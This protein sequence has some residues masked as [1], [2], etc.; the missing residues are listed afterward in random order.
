MIRLHHVLAISVLF[1]VFHL[2]PASG[3]DD[4][5]APKVIFDPS[6]PDSVKLITPFSGSDSDVTFA[7]TGTGLDVNVIAGGKAK[8]PGITITPAA[9]LDA[10]GYGHLEF[11]CTNNGTKKIRIT[12]KVDNA[13]PW[14]ENRNSVD[15]TGL[16]PGETKTVTAIFG[17]QFGKPGYALDPKDIS[18][19]S[20]FSVPSDLAESYHIEAI[21]AAGPTGEK[22][23]V[24]PNR[25]AVIPAGGVLLGGDATTEGKLLAPRGGAKSAF[26]ADG[27]SLQVDFAG[28]KE[29]LVMFKP[30]AGMWN[31]NE[32][33]EVKVHVKNTGSSPVTP[34][35]QLQSKAGDSDPVFAAAPIAPGAEADI[36]I[37]FA[38]ATPWKCIVDPDQEKLE[39][40]KDWIGENQ[41]GTGTKYASNSTV[42]V[43][44][45][46]D[47]S[48][49]AKSFQVTSIVGDMP[50]AD[51]LPDWLGQKPPVDGDWTKTFEDNFDGNTID[52]K[53]WN[54]YF[55]QNYYLGVR[56]HYSKDNVI[57]KDGTVTLRIEKKDG[58]QN[59]DPA[60]VANSYAM[61][62]LD[63]YGKWTQRY[64]YFE[65]RMKLTKS[66]EVTPCFW[67]MPDRGLT[68]GDYNKRASTK[69]GGMELDIMETL[70]IWGLCRHDFGF[71]WDSYQK[72]HKSTGAVTLYN[73]PDKDGFITVGLL[74]TPGSLVEYDNGKETGRWES[75]RI[76][77]VESDF[78]LYNIIGGWETEAFDDKA[79]PSDFVIDYVRAWQRKDLASPDDGPKPNDGAPYPP[80][81]TATA[82]TTPT[83]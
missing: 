34:G 32:D 19:I 57:V 24:D 14:Q 67:L 69:D 3:T 23:F 4:P 5:A 77:N 61:G 74:W 30:A 81:T 45:V 31:L 56:G 15:I 46:S 12:F 58:H 8:Y 80:G 50:T 82:A 1:S 40:K 18:S 44:F 10:S 37:P 2:M 39:V 21:Q 20:I 76:S 79:L 41:T 43:T 48:E 75:P 26:A 28:G 17:Y 65:A 72:Y 62:Y 51:P 83:P 36:I 27:K 59:D 71:H 66:P 70:S 35:V 55:P 64:G 16:N 54:I 9:P 47:K 6:S 29:E 7:A 68:A 78:I 60:R 11:K 73:H 52:L 53:K 13:G 25:V 33:L 63:T 42:S 22:P 38:A 49:G